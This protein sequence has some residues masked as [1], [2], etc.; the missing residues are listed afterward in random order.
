MSGPYTIRLALLALIW[1][2][3]IYGHGWGYFDY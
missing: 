1:L 3:L 2:V